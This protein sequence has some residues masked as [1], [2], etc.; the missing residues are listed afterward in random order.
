M[1]W[2]AYS[3]ILELTGDLHCGDLPLGFVA[4]AFPYVPCH[5]PL[6]AMVPAAVRLLDMPDVRAS[7]ASVE[8]LFAN[9]VRCTSLYVI[10]EKTGNSLF[11]WDAESMQLLEYTYLS[12]NYGVALDSQIRSAKDGCLFETEVLLAHGR[13]C[14]KPTLVAGAIFIREGQVGDLALSAEGSV[15]AKGKSVKLANIL[16]VMQLG[17]ERGSLGRPAKP[18]LAPLAGKLWGSFD[19]DLTG[20]FPSILVPSVGGRGPMPI[21]CADSSAVSGTRM[22]VTGRRHR[23]KGFGEAMEAAEIVF[24]PG[25]KA[26]SDVRAQMSRLRCVV[27]V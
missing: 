8:E 20:A 4:R 13:S 15:S 11:P 25:W 18:A 21:L 7:Y 5:I 6:F 12:S 1:T 24:A 10:D 3:L 9:N 17:G 23:G 2:N 16:A 26:K 22:V 19:F 14:T 27:A